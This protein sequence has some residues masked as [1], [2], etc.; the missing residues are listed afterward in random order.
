MGK[1]EC[2]VCHENFS[3]DFNLGR[4]FTAIHCCND[5][6]SCRK[7]H[8]YFPTKHDLKLHLKNCSNN[9]ANLYKC[10]I[11]GK[12][13]L[14][15]SNWIRHENNPNHL[16]KTEDKSP[17]LSCPEQ[18]DKVNGKVKYSKG[19][20]FE[21]TK[22]GGK[23]LGSKSFDKHKL[24]CKKRSNDTASVTHPNSCD[25]RGEKRPLSP[26]PNVNK[27]QRGSRRVKCHKCGSELEDY[28][29]LYRHKL[30]V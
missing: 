8:K 18:I 23:F 19:K 1:T 9:E 26:K 29:S 5:S 7:C 10:K 6:F 25:S 11:C 27:K 24:A 13:F 4:H 20:T 14:K 21:C 30:Q 16:A 15:K 17:S 22:C 2:P 3:K 12:T 28:R